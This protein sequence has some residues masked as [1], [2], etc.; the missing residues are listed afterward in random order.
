MPTENGSSSATEP[1]PGSTR[2]NEF[3]SL[4]SLLS[5]SPSP[6]PSISPAE[7]GEFEDKQKIYSMG[8]DD[9]HPEGSERKEEGAVVA[10]GQ[11][12]DG[13]YHTPTSPRNRVPLAVECPPAPRKPAGVGLRRRRRRRRKSRGTRLC[14]WIEIGDELLELI[15]CTE[16]GGLWF[17]RKKARVLEE[18]EEEEEEEEAEHEIS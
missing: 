8:E 2:R 9:H 7:A 18:E 10:R 17:R 6:S 16:M 12:D 11:E 14:C 13:G 1:F 15:F 4:K 3:E 5:F